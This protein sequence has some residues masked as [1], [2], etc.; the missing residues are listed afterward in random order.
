MTAEGIG[1]VGYGAYIPKF[2]I[3]VEEIARSWGRDAESLKKSLCVNEKTVPGIDEDTTTMAVE[4][5]RKALSMA[6]VPGQDI[7]ALFIG[8]ESHPYA[9]KPTATVVAEAIRLNRSL[10]SADLEF[11]CKAGTSAVQIVYGMVKSGMINYGLAIGSD[12]AQA[13]P[14]DALE[15]T[16]SAGAATILLGKKCVIAE[17]DSTCSFATDTPDFWRR[18]NQP[19]PR[20]AGHFT[21]KPAYYRHITECT[22][23]ILEM[24]SSRPSDFDHVIFHQPNGKFPVEA[25]KMLGFT[26]KQTEKGLLVRDIGNCYSASTLIGLCSVLDEA[27]PGQKI[28]LVSYGSGAGADG[29]VLRTTENIENARKGIMKV[30][31]MMK[32]TKYLAYEEYMRHAK[33][34]V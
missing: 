16:A 31:E 4:S 27:L 21:G 24:A 32:F 13:N 9:V 22:E 3:K 20:H 19:Y 28:L 23:K 1:I 26:E 18:Q 2:R 8:S 11:A 29:F 33:R 7:N 25:A 17:I 6:K 12:V 30:R 5:S 34:L 10:F 14:N 15:C